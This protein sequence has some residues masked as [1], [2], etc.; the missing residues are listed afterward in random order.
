MKNSAWYLVGIYRRD[1]SRVRWEWMPE[2]RV[3]ADVD[4]EW[5]TR[6]RRYIVARDVA[7]RIQHRRPRDIG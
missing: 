1:G 7:P 2:A 5:F 4:G 3:L 6:T